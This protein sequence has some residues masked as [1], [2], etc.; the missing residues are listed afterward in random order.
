MFFNVYKIVPQVK[1]VYGIAL[2]AAHTKQ[3]AINIF[4][5]DEYNKHQFNEFTCSCDVIP[6]MD[7][8]TNTPQVILNCIHDE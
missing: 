8:T 4:C 2:V 6:N 3:D 5:K 7:Y 1:Y